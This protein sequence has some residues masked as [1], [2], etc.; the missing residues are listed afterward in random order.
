MIRIYGTFNRSH[1]HL[2]RHTPISA[3]YQPNLLFWLPWLF[4]QKSDAKKSNVWWLCLEMKMDAQIPHIHTPTDFMHIMMSGISYSSLD[5][6][7]E[8]TY[9]TFCHRILKQFLMV[10]N[11]CDNHKVFGNLRFG[12]EPQMHIPV[13]SIIWWVKHCPLM[14]ETLST[15]LSHFYS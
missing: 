4:E 11:T 2:S 7:L 5:T 14:S 1:T 8:L 6:H 15:K 13:P 9:S 10:F 3:R 12:P